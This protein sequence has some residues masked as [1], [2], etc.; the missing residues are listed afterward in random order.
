MS[1]IQYV[2]KKEIVFE[3]VGFEYH[4]FSIKDFSAKF[5]KEKNVQL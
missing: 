3:N 4:S 1:D 2:F 5:E